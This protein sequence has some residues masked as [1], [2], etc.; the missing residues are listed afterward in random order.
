MNTFG[1][2]K[3]IP[4]VRTYTYDAVCGASKIEVPQTYLLPEEF[5]P[6]V[7]NQGTVSACVAFA[8]A[9]ILSVFNKKEFGEKEEVSE[10]FIYA[11]N[12]EA[13]YR[14]MY[15]QSTIDLTTKVGSPL[16]KYYNKLYE[17]PELYYDLQEEENLDTLVEIAKKYKIKGYVGFLR[18]EVE[19][20]K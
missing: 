2:L 20:V 6:K 18:G 5:R 11:Y 9:E 7:T 4:S 3:E 17:M 15:P 12:R 1:C 19:E 13:P 14:G 8:I 16:K 10:G